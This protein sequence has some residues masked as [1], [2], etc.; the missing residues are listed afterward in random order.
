MLNSGGQYNK[1]AEGTVLFTNNQTAG[2]GQRGNRW[3]A[4]P[5][6]NLT[7]SLVLYPK[8]LTIQEQFCLTI[9]ISL[10]IFDLLT[11]LPLKNPQIKWPNDL[12]VGEMKVGGMLIENLIKGNQLEASVVG[13]GLNVNQTQFSTAA[14]TSLK[15]ETGQFFNREELICKLLLSIEKRYLQLKRLGRN[16][17]GMVNE[18]LKAM[19][20]YQQTRIFRAGSIVFSGIITGIDSI[21]RLLVEDRQ[22][23]TQPYAIKEIEF[24]MENDIV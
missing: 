9:S 6:Q 2:R 14:A 8:F 23:L 3:E 19:L 13:I 7:F 4:A 22:G 17:E 15:L 5:E 24:V 1:P 11:E 16:R 20:G 10:A 18:Y 21:G 12:Y